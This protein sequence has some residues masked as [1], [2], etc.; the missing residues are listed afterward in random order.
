MGCVSSKSTKLL[1]KTELIELQNHSDEL[2]EK[3]MKILQWMEKEERPS[4]KTHEYKHIHRKDLIE[5]ET[6]NHWEEA[7]IRE[8][9]LIAHPSRIDLCESKIHCITMAD[10]N[11]RILCN[12]DDDDDNDTENFW[13]EFEA[14]EQL[15]RVCVV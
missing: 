9:E 3:R 5:R 13:T 14:L 11:L 12:D 8:Q 15:N 10:E 2:Q 6:L 4:R 7:W 1:T